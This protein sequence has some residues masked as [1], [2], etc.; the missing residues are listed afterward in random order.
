MI[1]KY[2]CPCCHKEYSEM[3]EQGQAIKKRGKCIACLVVRGEKI[4]FNPYEFEIPKTEGR[5]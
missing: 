1:N 3:T 2:E 4:Q 5:D